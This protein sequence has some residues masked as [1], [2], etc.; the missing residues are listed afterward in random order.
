MG[1]GQLLGDELHGE[2]GGEIFLSLPHSNLR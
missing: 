1:L 2:N